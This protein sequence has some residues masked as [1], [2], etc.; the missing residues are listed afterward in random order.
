MNVSYTS[1]EDPPSIS[2]A[3]C[4]SFCNTFHDVWDVLDKYTNHTLLFS[5]LEEVYKRNV[6]E[7]NDVSGTGRKHKAE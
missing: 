1:A 7:Y 2:A 4:R 3:S 6:Q 5:K